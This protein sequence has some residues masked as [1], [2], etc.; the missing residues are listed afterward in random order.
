MNEAQSNNAQSG[1]MFGTVCTAEKLQSSDSVKDRQA[2]FEE[3]IDGFLNVVCRS[4][5]IEMKQADRDLPMFRDLLD[6]YLKSRETWAQAQRATADDFNMFE[7]MNVVGDENRHSR[8]LAW[9]LDR[10]I[11]HGTHAQGNLGFRLFLEK[12]AEELKMPRSLDS[13]AETNY[14]IRREV[15]GETSR[16]DVEIAARGIFILQIENKI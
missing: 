5:E 9:L 11:E 10:R 6:G 13:Y 1:E 2:R 14:W 7:V 3:L 15:S 4:Q 12:F 8:I 16:M